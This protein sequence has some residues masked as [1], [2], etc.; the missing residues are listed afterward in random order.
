MHCASIRDNTV[1]MS[2]Q[3]K[4]NSAPEM[5]ESFPSSVQGELGGDFQ[6]TCSCP[7]IF[8]RHCSAL[9]FW[10]AKNINRGL[11]QYFYMIDDILQ[12]NKGFSVP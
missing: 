2:E 3:N 5:T 4:D 9:L 10:E 7:G 8:H 1:Y 6:E 11:L 12:S